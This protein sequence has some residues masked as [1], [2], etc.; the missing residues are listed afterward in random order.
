MNSLRRLFRFP[1]TGKPL[2]GLF[3]GFSVF[4]PEKTPFRFPVTGKP[5]IQPK[6][7]P[8]L[9]P[10][11]P[12]KN[13]CFYSQASWLAGLRKKTK[14]VAELPGIVQAGD[15]VLHEPSKEVLAEEIG[16]DGYRAL[17]E[18]YLEVEV[19]GLDQEGKPIK[20]DARGWQAHI[21]QHECDHLE[22]TLYVDKMVKR[23]FRTIDNVDLPLAKGCPKQGVR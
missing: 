7:R 4:S 13:T 22:G 21:L 6:H 15:P 14:V 19:T 16:V 18:R 17:V 12:A 10:S 9:N 2:S 3:S 20:V 8:I 23:T 11:F 5:L 1:V